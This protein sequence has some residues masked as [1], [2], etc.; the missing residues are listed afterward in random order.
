MIKQQPGDV[1]PTPAED[2]IGDHEPAG[3]MIFTKW[4]DPLP[5]LLPDGR[6]V[7]DSKSVENLTDDEVME[8]L[9]NIEGADPEDVETACQ[10]PAKSR[11]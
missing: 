11:Q 1:E 4:G 9:D 3:Q 6:I 7:R 5:R 10:K 2:R 8:W